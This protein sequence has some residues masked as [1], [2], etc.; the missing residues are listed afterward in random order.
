MLTPDQGIDALPHEV[1]VRAERSGDGTEFT[2]TL[3]ID[4]PA[5]AAHFRNRGVLQFV[6]R[7]LLAT[8]DTEAVI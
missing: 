4:T 6:L 7:Q 2:A 8:D 3:R 5:E 1:T